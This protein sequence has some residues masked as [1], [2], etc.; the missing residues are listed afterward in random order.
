MTYRPADYLTYT[1]AGVPDLEIFLNY[2]R[3][4]DEAYKRGVRD[5]K[6]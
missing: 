1:H 3:A 6:K 2:F 4:L 5:G